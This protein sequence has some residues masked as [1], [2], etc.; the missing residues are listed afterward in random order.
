MV[1]LRTALATISALAKVQVDSTEPFEEGFFFGVV[2]PKGVMAR[3]VPRQA[4]AAHPPTD[5]R[6]PPAVETA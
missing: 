6:S 1:Y 2:F 4:R 5:A 3:F